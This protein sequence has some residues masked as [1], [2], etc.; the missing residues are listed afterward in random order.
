KRD[1]VS[2]ENDTN[3]LTTND[4]DV[5]TNSNE[6]NKRINSTNGKFSIQKMIRQ[7]F[8]SWRTR[9]KPPSLSTPT[10]SSVSTNMST[11]PPIPSSN[12]RYMTTDNDVSQV[13]QSTTLSIITA[14]SNQTLPQRI[15]VTEQIPPLQARSKS[16]DTATLDFDR[17]PPPPPPPPNIRGYIQ[18]PWTN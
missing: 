12:A 4:N 14:D 7:G 18:S 17:P 8:S 3:Y 6:A 2:S 1:L 11:P 10:P 13:Q 15:I 9:R 5:S 16:I